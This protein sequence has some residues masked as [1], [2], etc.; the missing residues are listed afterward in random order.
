MIE[1]ECNRTS[2]PGRL[3]DLDERRYERLMEYLQLS[4]ALKGVLCL[5][6]SEVGAFRCFVPRLIDKAAIKDSCQSCETDGR[7]RGDIC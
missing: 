3:R 7:L 4:R 5:S 1:N 6:K 2:A